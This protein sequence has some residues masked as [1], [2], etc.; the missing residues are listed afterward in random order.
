VTDS[1]REA[2]NHDFTAST[3][4][5]IDMVKAM[6]AGVVLSPNGEE[7][8]ISRLNEYSV[9]DSTD[10]QDARLQAREIVKLAREAQ[11][12]IGDQK[13]GETV[14]EFLRRFSEEKTLLAIKQCEKIAIDKTQVPIK[15]QVRVLRDYGKAFEQ[16]KEYDHKLG[17]MKVLDNPNDKEALK[18]LTHFDKIGKDNPDFKD[19]R[20]E[21]MR[22]GNLKIVFVTKGFIPNADMFITKTGK[23]FVDGLGSN[24]WGSKNEPKALT[25]AHLNEGL[26]FMYQNGTGAHRTIDES[27]F[28]MKAAPAAR[29]AVAADSAKVAAQGL[30]MKP[31]DAASAKLTS[32]LPIEK[33]VKGLTDKAIPMSDSEVLAMQSL[34]QRI[35]SGQN[36]KLEA[37]LADSLNAILRNIDD[38]AKKDEG[39]ADL[40]KLLNATKQVRIGER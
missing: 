18:K 22:D 25:D 3:G 27:E 16:V 24:D 26:K 13:E 33:L 10:N 12:K 5:N 6:D 30:E 35:A 14:N 38:P 19:V 40:R 31:A 34:Q 32:A 23:I 37:K 4:K 8:I 28:A 11:S 2:I 17:L 15:D 21:R 1:L 36:P 9:S 39:V 7:K 20:A 29:T